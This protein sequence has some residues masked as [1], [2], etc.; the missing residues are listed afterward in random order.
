MGEEQKT[1]KVPFLRLVYEVQRRREDGKILPSDVRA[2]LDDEGY[3]LDAGVKEYLKVTYL[4]PLRDAASDLTPKRNSRLSQI[5]AGHPAFK[6][7]ENH[8][9]YWSAYSRSSMKK[10]VDILKALKL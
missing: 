9:F 2:G 7:K 8:A 10:F 1:R 6:G 3:L 4:K 5:L